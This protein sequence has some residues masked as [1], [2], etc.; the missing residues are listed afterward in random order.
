MANTNTLSLSQNN[1]AKMLFGCFYGN[2]CNMA[3]YNESMDNIAIKNFIIDGKQYIFA[4]QILLTVEKKDDMYFAY[5]EIFDI[6]IYTKNYDDIEKEYDEDFA[7]LYES[8][9]LEEDC[10]LDENAKNLKKKYLDYCKVQ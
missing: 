9:A 6:F 7:E 8:F 2:N 3:T 10:N 1:L 4:K 5:D